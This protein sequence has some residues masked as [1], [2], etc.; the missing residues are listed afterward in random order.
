M[1]QIRELINESIA[2]NLGDFKEL[3]A[4]PKSAP[5]KIDKKDLEI[6][7]LKSKILELE[8]KLAVFQPKTIKIIKI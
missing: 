8:K 3:D 7:E 6:L 4:Q 5:T 1:S 2:N